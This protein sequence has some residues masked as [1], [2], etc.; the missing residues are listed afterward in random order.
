MATA[1]TE[2]PITVRES[3]TGVGS[4]IAT[5]AATSVIGNA[6]V[7][8]IGRGAGADFHVAR[9]GQSAMTVNLPMVIGTTLLPVVIGGLLLW[10]AARRTAR[11]PRVLAWLGLAVGIVTVGAPFSMEALNSTRMSLAAMHI[12]TG[13]VWWLAV[14][15]VP[16]R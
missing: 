6:I 4:A 7:W 12:L 9:P 10:W 8:A 16:T 14:R 5:V 1:T 3:R 15:R 11:G 2:A 13:L